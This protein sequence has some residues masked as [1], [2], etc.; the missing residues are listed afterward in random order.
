VTVELKPETERLVQ[1]EL[2]QGNFDSADE[3]ILHAVRLLNPAH[4]AVEAVDVDLSRLTVRKQ[5][6][7]KPLGQFLLESPLRESGI[8]LER[9]ADLPRPVDL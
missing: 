5:P 1:V 2:E 3:V 6:A 8:Q 7:K 9:Q 4:Q